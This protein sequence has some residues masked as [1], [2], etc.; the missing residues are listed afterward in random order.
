MAG[1]IDENGQQWEHCNECGEFVRIEDL[2]FQPHSEKLNGPCDICI[3]CA[4]QAS[5]LEAIVPSPRWIPQ[6]ES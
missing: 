4:N 5:N 1:V 3:K 2:G 6:Y